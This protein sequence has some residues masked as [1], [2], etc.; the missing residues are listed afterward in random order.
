MRE[1]DE[2]L[3]LQ[4][5]ELGS[6][7]T[8]K[9][10]KALKV[11][12]FDA[13]NLYLEAKD[14]FQAIWFEEHIRQK[15]QIHFVK[16]KIKI[17]LTIA[18]A[19]PRKSKKSAY[20]TAAQA[21]ISNVSQFILNFD[22]LDPYCTFDHYISSEKNSMVEKY[23]RSLSKTEI[24]NPI[25]VYGNPG[26]GKTHLLMA[27]A[28]ALSQRGLR[29]I[30]ARADT[31]T[32]HVVSSIRIGEMSI[33]REAYRNSDVLIIDDIQTF[34]KKGA[35]QEELFHTFNAL[36][37]ENKQM[38]F[39][40]NCLP[41]E[42]QNVEPRL[43]SR[44]EWGIVLNLFPLERKEL[45]KALKQKAKFLNF[46]IQDKVIDFLLDHFPSGCKALTKSLEALVLRSHLNKQTIRHSGH[47]ITV[48]EAKQILQDL[49]QQEK[50]QALTPEKLIRMIAEI[51][52]IKSDDITGDA[53]TRDCVFPRQLAMFACREKLNMPFTRLG[54]L[55][56][57]D[58][59]TVMA[60]VKRIQKAIDANNQE[61]LDA[62]QM[63]HKKL[64]M[65]KDKG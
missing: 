19:L 55:F 65:N 60:S 40:A 12:N 25:Y 20:T 5:I 17:H 22:P 43:I 11:I 2:F 10:L 23:L 63:L 3:A 61:T 42:L 58:H 41:P 36:H 33:F 1:W 52:G 21:K 30:Y 39:S 50:D 53:Q 35:T 57:R 46:Q 26:T 29:V 37:L 27:V 9:W 56:S 34:S 44:F 54:E 7:T 62:Y 48:H 64:D 18:N 15:A 49:I 32:E 59:S 51:F 45:E 4:E 6:E 16:K 38:I 24:I 8:H 28:H 13:R 14:S 31:F 47:G